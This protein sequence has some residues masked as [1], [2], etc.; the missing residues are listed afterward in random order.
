MSQSINYQKSEILAFKKHQLF[1]LVAAIDSYPQFLPWCTSVNI[2]E[3]NKDNIIAEMTIGALGFNYHYTSKITLQPYDNIKV[4]QL[5]GPFSL[6]HSVWNFVDLG[7]DTTRIDFSI[8][9][10][11]RSN[12]LQS[13]LGKIFH[14]ASMKMISAFSDRATQLYKNN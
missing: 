5:S 8:V 2:I 3:Q 6:L 11:I 4:E 9:F 1:D 14:R 12:L 10:Q 7:N 13:M